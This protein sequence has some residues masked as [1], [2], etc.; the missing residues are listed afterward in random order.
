AR[1]LLVTGSDHPYWSNF[2]KPG[3]GIGYEHTFIASLADFLDALASGSR[4]RPDF[5]DARD[6]HLVLDAIARSAAAGS[7]QTP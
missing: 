2:W 6:V 3:H 7:W 1:N 5:E 4:F